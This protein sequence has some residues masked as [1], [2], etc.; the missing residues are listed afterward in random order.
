MRY[1]LRTLQIVVGAGP[2]LLAFIW[3]ARWLLLLALLL[4]ATLTVWFIVS[5]ALARLAANVFCSVMR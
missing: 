5:Y 3:L 2:P 4:L 1:S